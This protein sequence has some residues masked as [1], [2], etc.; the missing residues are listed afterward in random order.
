MNPDCT[1]RVAPLSRGAGLAE[2]L[3]RPGFLIRLDGRGRMFQSLAF[4]ELV[5]RLLAEES[6]IVA[7]DLSSC[8][9]LDSTWLGCLL[10]LH[11][12]YSPAGCGDARFL[13]YAPGATRQ[14]LFGPMRLEK[15]FA[16]LDDAPQEGAPFT[17]VPFGEHERREHS[18]H[19]LEAHD[20][21][22]RHDCPDAAA[23]ERIVRQLECELKGER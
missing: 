13:I 3:D 15:V 17:V 7:I 12:T 9:Y 4:K 23:F 1:L 2:Q 19:V 14:K 20:R 6:R 21:L 11:Q 18:L 10:G 16:F 22:A 8:E 5:H